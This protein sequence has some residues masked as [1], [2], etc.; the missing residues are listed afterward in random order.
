MIQI[1]LEHATKG[2]TAY[3]ELTD[4]LSIVT[5]N[6]GTGKTHLCSMIQASLDEDNGVFTISAY[7]TVT[8]KETSV[9]FA[10]STQILQQLLT[11]PATERSVI[12]CDEYT[13]DKLYKEPALRNN[14]TERESH[15][16]L[17]SRDYK[18]IA[19]TAKIVELLYINK[20]YKFS[21]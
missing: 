13:T 2:L 1:K 6:S 12:V 9:Y 4:R 7:D 16:L 15:F 11:D 5:G 14:L 21:T 8:K 20:T 19:P 3:L 17:F 18:T 10:R